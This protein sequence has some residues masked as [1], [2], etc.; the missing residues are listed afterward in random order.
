MVVVFA[1][2]PIDS[3]RRTTIKPW[4]HLM[5]GLQP[6]HRIDS[7][8]S[9]NLARASWTTIRPDLI[10]R[11]ATATAAGQTAYFSPTCSMRLAFRAGR[12][13]VLWP[14]LR[15]L[16]SSTDGGRDEHGGLMKEERAV[17]ERMLTVRLGI[18][19][20]ADDCR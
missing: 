1:A 5:V 2:L 9:H 14:S 15:H 6:G 16:D 4:P 17:S 7:S 19:R 11:T 13:G 20:S 8:D 10:A 18:L 3:M 12:V